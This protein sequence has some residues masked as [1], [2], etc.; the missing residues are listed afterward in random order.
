MK[1]V[2]EEDSALFAAEYASK[3][4]ADY[5]DV[6]LED[7]YNQLITVANDKVQRGIINR[8]HG[9]GTRTLVNDAWEFQSK[10]NLT[11]KSHIQAAEITFKMTKASSKHVPTPGIV[12]RCFIL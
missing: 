2:M 3:L 8:K 12:G 5:A 1:S 9:M 6:R 7:H 11:K 10:T 4:G